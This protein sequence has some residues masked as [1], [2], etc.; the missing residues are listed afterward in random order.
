MRELTLTEIDAE[1]AEQLPAREL[2]GCCRG[3]SYTP[4]NQGGNHVFV[5]RSNVGNSNHGF[6]AIQ[7]NNT[8]D[9]ASNNGGYPST[10]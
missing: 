1:L 7:V 8:G 5:N 6:L 9:I 2:M 3:G 4:S 10:L